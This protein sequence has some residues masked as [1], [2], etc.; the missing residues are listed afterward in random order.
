MLVG[1]GHTYCSGCIKGLIKEG[2]REICKAAYNYPDR[3][4]WL[5]P[6]FS[7][8]SACP[9]CRQP[10]PCDPSRNEE[11]YPLNRGFLNMITIAKKKSAPAPSPAKKKLSPELCQV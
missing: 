2:V 8:V 10:T 4:A 5:T 11:Q 7:F 1:C 3:K 9:E 6:L